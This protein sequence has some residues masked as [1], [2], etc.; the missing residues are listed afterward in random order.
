MQDYE[1]ARQAF[2][3]CVLSCPSNAKAWI[4]WAQVC[5]IYFDCLCDEACR[6][7]SVCPRLSHQLRTCMSVRAACMLF[8]LWRFAFADGEA[9]QV[10]HCQ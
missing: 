4:S 7:S 10:S 2:Q 3:E 5:L 9:H 6:R 8:I 1:A